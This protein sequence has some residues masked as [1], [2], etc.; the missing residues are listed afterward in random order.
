M[1]QHRRARKHNSQLTAQYNEGFWVLKQQKSLSIE[2]QNFDEFAYTAHQL[3]SAS[4]KA[5]ISSAIFSSIILVLA[6]IAVG[7]TMYKGSIYVFIRSDYS[8]LEHCKCL[9]LIQVN[10]FE[11]IM[12]ITRIPIRLSKCTRLPQNGLLALLK[13]NQI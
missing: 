13:H 4:I 6:Y 9:L 8:Q 1:K 7:T 11:P 5:V 2:K 10:F 3:K 12:A